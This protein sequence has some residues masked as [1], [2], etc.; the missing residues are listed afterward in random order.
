MSQ[1]GMSRTPEGRY[2]KLLRILPSSY[3]E[4]REE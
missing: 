3:R 1:T 2:R 4:A